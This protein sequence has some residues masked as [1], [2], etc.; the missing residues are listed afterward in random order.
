[1]NENEDDDLLI[2]DDFELVEDQ[3]LSILHTKKKELPEYYIEFDVFTRE[4]TE[5]S[6][7]QIIQARS[8]RHNIFVKKEDDIL[9]KILYSKLPP[10]KVKAWF[11]PITNEHDLVLNTRRNNVADQFFFVQN[12]KD[13]P[14]PIHLDCDLIRKCIRVTFSSEEFKKYISTVSRDEDE[15]RL[16]DEIKFYCFHENNPTLLYGSFVVKVNELLENHQTTVACHWFPD[17]HR[18]FEN[19]A[20]MHMGANFNISF[21]LTEPEIKVEET[22]LERPQILY[23]QEG[24]TVSFQSIM[25]NAANYK[26]QDTVNFYCYQEDDPS[27]L[28]FK[29]NVPKESLDK[30]NSFSVKLQFEDKIKILSDHAHLY[31]EDNDVSTYYKF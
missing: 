1:M 15:M 31:I 3:E 14:G 27:K 24:S 5:I 23:K 20:F 13:V 7:V 8:F 18:E 28:L 19:Y 2:F 26:I 17:D 29:L 11:N 6:P 30:F 9:K 21:G 22:V 10:S 4:V 16:N 25:N 12:K